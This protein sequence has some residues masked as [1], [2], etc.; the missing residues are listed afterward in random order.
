MEA[1]SLKFVA[2][3][4]GAEIRS[5]DAATPINNISTDSRLAPAGGLFLALRGER[6]DGH[7]FIAEVAARATP[8]QFWRHAA[9][10]SL[11]GLDRE[12]GSDFFR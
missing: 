10:H 4:C 5:G 8:R 1:R 6:F 2:G 11:F 12:V 7:D 3:A 9:I